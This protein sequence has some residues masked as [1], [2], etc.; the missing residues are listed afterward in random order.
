MFHN[1][2]DE[3][4]TNACFHFAVSRTRTGSEWRIDRRHR[5]CHRRAPSLARDPRPDHGPGRDP[6]DPQQGTLWCG[7]EEHAGFRSVDQH[8]DLRSC[9]RVPG[10]RPGGVGVL[11]QE[12]SEEPST[13]AVLK[14]ARRIAP[15][16]LTLRQR[17]SSPG[18]TRCAWGCFFLQNKTPG[19]CRV[20]FF[21]PFEPLSDLPVY[22]SLFD[23][24]S[25]FVFFLSASYGELEFDEVSFCVD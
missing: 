12:H 14:L 10:R 17:D 24:L 22:I 3:R 9:R 23:A 16:Q 25:L 13:L 5:S 15:P 11:D 21:I 18:W 6:D 20:L 19:C 7:S 1:P 2:I 8:D 4:T